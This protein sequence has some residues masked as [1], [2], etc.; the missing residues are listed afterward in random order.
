MRPW[1]GGPAGELATA[2]LA[3]NP[4]PMTLEGT[5][6]WVLRAPGAAD[7]IVLDPGP[8]DLPEHLVRVSETAGGGVALTLLSHH[9]ADHVGGLPQW[10]ALAGGPV[11]GAGI[12]EPWEPQRLTAAGL[13]IEVLATPGHTADS[14]C[15]LLPDG[16][17][18]TGDTVLGSG[19]TVVPW[20]EGNL[21]DYLASLEQLLELARDG[22]LRRLAPGHGPVVADPLAHLTVLRDHR[23]ARLAQVRAAL[24]AGA[25]GAGAVRE[26]VYGDLSAELAPAAEAIVRAQLAHLGESPD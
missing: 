15:F 24:A 20:P 26:M 22:R 18:L 1:R 4:G 12:G 25:R 2:V 19:T 9:H 11:R 7:A 16:T 13:T 23:L 14:A 17:L 6:T 8:A 10:T 5:N 21:T 3:P